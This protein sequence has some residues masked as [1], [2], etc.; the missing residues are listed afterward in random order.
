MYFYALPLDVED[1]ASYTLEIGTQQITQFEIDK[2][3]G[4]SEDLLTKLHNFQTKLIKYF[5]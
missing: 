4:I 2:E 3:S 1:D 5:F